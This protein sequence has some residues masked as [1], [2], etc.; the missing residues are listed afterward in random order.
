MELT[1]E[2]IA[3]K[4]RTL[5]ADI[6]ELKNE[7]EHWQ[8]K[9]KKAKQHDQYYKAITYDTEI[10]KRID[11]IALNQQNIIQLVSQTQTSIL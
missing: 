4:I 1:G 3:A 10:N 2:Q 8:K 5:K 7:V 6:Q 9:K 11:K